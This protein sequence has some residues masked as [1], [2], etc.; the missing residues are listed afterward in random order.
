MMGTVAKYQIRSIC[1]EEYISFSFR[2]HI[3]GLPQARWSLLLNNNIPQHSGL[4]RTQA[5]FLSFCGSRVLAESGWVPGGQ[6]M[7]REA[8]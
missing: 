6:E 8:S 3:E 2:F 1:F 7:T 4:G 5:L